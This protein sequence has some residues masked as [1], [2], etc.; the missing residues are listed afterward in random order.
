M[1]GIFILR[2]FFASLP[3]EI[4]ESA[5]IDG[6]SEFVAYRKILLPLSKPILATVAIIE[7]LSSWN[8]YVWPL[9][10]ISDQKLRTVTVGLAY[11]RSEFGIALGD[12]MAGNVLASVPLVIL[13][14][15]ATRYFVEGLSSG[16]LKM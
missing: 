6:A 8:D 14:C 12:L 13:F 2:S 9:V 4:F 7:V 3:E 1:F 16:A 11:F 10:T 15:V 5:R